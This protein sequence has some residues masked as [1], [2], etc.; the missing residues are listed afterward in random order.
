MYCQTICKTI[1]ILI[2]TCFSR[3]AFAQ[4][5]SQKTT[6]DTERVRLKIDLTDEDLRNLE[7][8]GRL[9]MRIPEYFKNRVA[10]IQ[11][12]YVDTYLE[13]KVRVTGEPAISEDIAHLTIDGLLLERV[14]FQPVEIRVFE[15]NFSQVQIN[16]EES[17]EDPAFVAEANEGFTEQEYD[18]QIAGRFNLIARISL[19]GR[20]SLASNIGKVQINWNDID[21]MTFIENE[22][23]KATVNLKTGDILTGLVDLS[24]LR[25][26]TKWGQVTIPMDD[27]SVILPNK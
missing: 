22:E 1:L 8:A 11:L 9:R 26:K 2:L 7:H 3:S 18:I 24:D 23:L 27:I 10:A 6:Q 5:N 16:Y 13:R 20:L 19:E 15:K 21:K 4:S 12:R 17:E 25:I 14:R